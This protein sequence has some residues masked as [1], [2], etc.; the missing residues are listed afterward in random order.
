MTE[1]LDIGF[2]RI[3]GVFDD[4]LETATFAR[5]CLQLGDRFISRCASRTG[6]RD[7]LKLPLHQLASGIAENWWTLLYEPWRPEEATEQRIARHHLDAFVPGFVFPSFGIWSAGIDAITVET[8]RVR[9]L[10][11]APNRHVLPVE[12]RIAARLSSSR[13]VDPRSL[14]RIELVDESRDRVS[15]SRQHVESQLFELVS[16]VVDWI[17]A[18]QVS[19]EASVLLER[20]SSVVRSID[21]PAERNYCTAAGRLGFDPYDP[22]TPDISVYAAELPEDSFDDLCEAA[23]FDE[24]ANASAW[25]SREQSTLDRASTI[26]VAD[27]GPRPVLDPRLPAWQS[28]YRAA[29]LLRHRL[30]LDDDPLKATRRLIGD[31][32]EILSGEVPAVVEGL[33]VRENSKVHKRVLARS[34]AQRRFRECRAAFLGWG[35]EPGDFPLLTTAST[36]RQQASRAFAAE[37]L[38]PAD[39]LRHAA[40]N[41]GLT[42]DQFLDIVEALDCPTTVVEHQA[43][44]HNIPIRGLY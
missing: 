39:Y 25:V 9:R 32:G 37:L 26:D 19:P 41:R 2:E 29:T 33:L 34:S 15:V 35:A 6:T 14:S 23:R 43:R 27:F 3:D 11:P 13:A 18:D 42:T 20:W 17:M 24:L 4:P 44:N 21:D 5:L 8:G 36:H 1:D 7:Y 38:C 10:S 30:S 31:T 16:A 40:G 28:G 22:A 12:A